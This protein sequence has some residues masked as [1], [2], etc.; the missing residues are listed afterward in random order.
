[1]LNALSVALVAAPQI[2]HADV[3]PAAAR[4][5]DEWL[6][7]MN[8]AFVERSYDGVFSYFDGT[9]LATLRVV[10][11]IVDGVQRERLVHLNGAPREILRRGDDVSCILQPGDAMLAL[12]E[13]I[14]SGPFARA[15]TRSF[16][17]I[18]RNYDMTLQG[19]DR[20]ADR[21]AVVI[22]VSPRDHDRYGYRLWL[23]RDKGLLLRSELVDMTG[24]RL[25]IFQFAHVTIDESVDRL[26]LEP[27][28]SDGAVVN[29]LTLAN[30]PNAAVVDH[31]PWYA[32][33]VPNGFAMA[34]RDVRRA[35]S[36][37]QPVD[38]LMYSDGLAAFFGVYREPA[39][40]GRS[41]VRV[42]QWGDGCGYPGRGRS[43]QCPLSGDCGRRTAGCDRATCRTL[44][45]LFP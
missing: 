13:S 45:P 7:F 38:T 1:M 30:A 16:E 15:F 22:H 31:M 21:A 33:W 3:D 18:S 17:G 42:A 40:N 12:Q 29:H 10:H 19:D 28:S 9:D 35:P 27:V 11:A 14:P 25:E 34:T 43:A 6:A 44:S 2:S 20:V 8:R 24:A 32:Q 23:D 39:G 36:T 4:S 26:A 5:A 41:H 37:D